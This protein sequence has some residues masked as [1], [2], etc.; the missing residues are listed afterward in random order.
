[1]W[2]FNK[3]KDLLINILRY[4]NLLKD[5]IIIVIIAWIM[6]LV[7]GKKA[8]TFQHFL[9][10]IAQG[11][12]WASYACTTIGA[13]SRCPDSNTL[14]D[15]CRNN[16]CLSDRHLEITES[17]NSEPIINLIEKAY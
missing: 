16:V 5:I 14:D 15:Y 2:Q 13:C 7:Q 1:M 8:F 3:V 4:L 11:R 6:K 17:V 12:L 9:A 10:A